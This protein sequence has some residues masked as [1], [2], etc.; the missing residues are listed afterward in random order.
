MSFFDGFKQLRR[1]KRIVAALHVHDHVRTLAAQSIT[2]S[3]KAPT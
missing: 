2:R 1:E 3:P